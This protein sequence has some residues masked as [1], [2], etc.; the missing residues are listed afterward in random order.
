MGLLETIES[1]DLEFIF[2]KVYRKIK[3]EMHRLLKE[4]VTINEYMVLKFLMKS[5][6]RSSDLSKAL[7][8]SASHITS[9]TDSLVE[10]GLIERKR[11]NKDRRVVDLILTEKG[12][13]L[14][15]LLTARKC[16]FLKEKLDIFTNE[17][18]ETLYKLF[19]K[20]EDHLN[21]MH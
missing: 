8:V 13:A 12:K 5:P 1:I 2:R 15:E 18:R 7:Q 3:D 10:K 9:V 11:S 4:Y 16:E 20:L 14:I 6:M 17:E 21:E 19:K